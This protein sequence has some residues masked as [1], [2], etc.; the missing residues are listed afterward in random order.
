MASQGYLSLIFPTSFSLL[1]TGIQW[2]NG[3]DFFQPNQVMNKMNVE[4]SFYLLAGF[5]RDE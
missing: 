3:V 4:I 1:V 5:S 2:M